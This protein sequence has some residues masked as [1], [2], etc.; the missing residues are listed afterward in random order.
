MLTREQVAAMVPTHNVLRDPELL[1]TLLREGEILPAP[2]H[3]K[4]HIADIDGVLYVHD[5][6]HRLV[7]YLLD[8]N[9]EIG[10]AEYVVQRYAL[11]DYTR[12]NPPRWLTPFDPRVEVRVP[13]FYAFKE[14]AQLRM[15]EVWV[16][17]NRHLYVQ[18]RQV[19]SMA[20]LAQ[21]M[22]R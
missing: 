12:W 21:K 11:E 1:Q 3:R 10:D 9:L 17:S 5:G 13:D 8:P 19:H 14:E 6:H 15:D 16:Q 20:D 7:A 18:P 2:E 22:S 4:I